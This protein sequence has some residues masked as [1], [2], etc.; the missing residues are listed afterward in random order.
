MQKKGATMEEKE[1]EGRL[2]KLMK[3]D[4]SAGTDAFREDLLSRCLAV[5]NEAEDGGVELDDSDLDM[6]AAAGNPFEEQKKYPR[7]KSDR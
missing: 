6:L 2:E 5:L 3:Q 4:L 7:L 1:F